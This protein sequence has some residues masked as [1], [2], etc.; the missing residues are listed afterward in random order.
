MTNKIQR[1]N[2]QTLK[3]KFKV[4]NDMRQCK[5]LIEDAIKE[6]VDEL[7]LMDKYIEF[8]NSNKF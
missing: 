4:I 5:G 6:N 1:I 3:D 2:L 7:A 8:M